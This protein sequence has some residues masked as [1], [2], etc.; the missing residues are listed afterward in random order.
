MQGAGGSATSRPLSSQHERL[1]QIALVDRDH[2]R[3]LRERLVGVGARTTEYPAPRAPR[4]RRA[5]PMPRP[6][7]DQV[8]RLRV[9]KWRPGSLSAPG[10]SVTRPVSC[11]QVLPTIVGVIEVEGFRRPDRVAVPTAPHPPLPPREP[12]APGVLRWSW[13]YRARFVTVL[14]LARQT[15]CRTCGCR[16]WRRTAGRKRDTCAQPSRRS[17]QVG[18]NGSITA[19][20]PSRGK[21]PSA[22]VRSRQTA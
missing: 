21:R 17:L 7:P 6:H 11:A 1:R 10:A 4:V 15:G 12:R 13:P 5:A 18:V 3:R 20:N 8:L 2:R 19:L 16:S 14:P 9:G 22:G